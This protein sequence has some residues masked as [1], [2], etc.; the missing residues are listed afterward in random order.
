[1]TQCLADNYRRWFD[2]ERDSHAKVL[3]SLATVPDDTRSSEQFQRAVDLLAHIAAARLMWLYRFGVA[4]EN[5]DLFPRNVAWQEL[6][7]LVGKMEAAWLNYLTKLDDSELGRIFE[8]QSYEGARFRGRV[9]DIL[10][11]LFGHSWY[12]RGQ[13]AALVRAMGG[14]PAVTDFVFWSREPV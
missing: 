5:A 3:S 10:T 4:S 9:E 7:A 14:E 1:M 8:Y 6:P 12:H 13:I 11:Q 2:Y